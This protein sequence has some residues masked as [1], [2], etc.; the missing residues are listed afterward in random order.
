MAAMRAVICLCL[1]WSAACSGVQ[2]GDSDTTPPVCISS[3]VEDVSDWSQALEGFAVS[4][5]ETLAPAQGSWSGTL[6]RPNGDEYPLTVAFVLNSG[7][8]RATYYE[9]V[10]GEHAECMGPSLSARAE[11]SVDAGATLS[12][13]LGAMVRYVAGRL[14]ISTLHQRTPTI[15][16]TLFPGSEGEPREAASLTAEIEHENGA[17]DGSWYWSVLVTTDDCDDEPSCSG[18]K[19]APLGNV[20]LTRR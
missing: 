14:S 19:V 20:R 8:L 3:R 15:T 11:L 2:V 13:R 16:T 18:L 5:E 1:V 17:W 4:P 10:E 7:S 12:G 9:P 6:R